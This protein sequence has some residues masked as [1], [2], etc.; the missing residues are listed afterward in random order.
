[1]ACPWIPLLRIASISDRLSMAMT[2]ATVYKT[3]RLLAGP[4]GWQRVVDL[5]FLIAVNVGHVLSHLHWL[6]HAKQLK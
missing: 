4:P 3:A 2:R 1:M 6:D 5:P